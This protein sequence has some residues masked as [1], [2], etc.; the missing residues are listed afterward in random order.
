[1]VCFCQILTASFFPEN[2]KVHLDPLLRV[3]YFAQY[4]FYAG[5]HIAAV[6]HAINKRV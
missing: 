5:F 6:F 2:C 1:M 4:R 3:K